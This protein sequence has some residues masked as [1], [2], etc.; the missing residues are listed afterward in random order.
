MITDHLPSSSSRFCRAGLEVSRPARH[1]AAAGAPPGAFPAGPSCRDGA[2]LTP[3]VEDSV[4]GPS[5]E[6]ALLSLADSA[7][8]QREHMGVMCSDE[9]S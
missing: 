3:H 7:S 9:S 5:E 4:P 6:E 2:L 1:H 8:L